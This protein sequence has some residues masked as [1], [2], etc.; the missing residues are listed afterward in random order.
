MSSKTSIP[1]FTQEQVDWISYQ[2]GCWYFDWKHKIGGEHQHRLGYAK[3]VLKQMLCPLKCQT[4][5]VK[6]AI[7]SWENCFDCEVTNNS[8]KYDKEGN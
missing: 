8:D 1:E 2:I 3:E 7:F 6:Y 4:C 5:K